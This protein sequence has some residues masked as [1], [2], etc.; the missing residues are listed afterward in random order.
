MLSTRHYHPLECVPWCRSYCYTYGGFGWVL[1][2]NWSECLST[3]TLYQGGGG[4][5]GKR[6]KRKIGGGSAGRRAPSTQPGSGLRTGKPARLQGLGKRWGTPPPYSLLQLQGWVGFGG[7][8]AGSRTSQAR[9]FEQEAADGAVHEHQSG[10]REGAAR[11]C[12]VKAWLPAESPRTPGA[13][14]WLGQGARLSGR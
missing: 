9:G 7:R 14:S 12:I 6:R 2:L 10:G 4:R 3:A 11:T 13:T 8:R 1:N 5:T